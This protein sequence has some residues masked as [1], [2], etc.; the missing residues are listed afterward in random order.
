MN[1]FKHSHHQVLIMSYGLALTH[2]KTFLTVPCD[3]LICDEGHKLKNNNI[4]IFKVLNALKTKRKIVLSGTPLQNDLNEFYCIVDFLNPGLLGTEKSFKH[5][6]ADPINKS[7]EPSAKPA[8]K[9][10][11]LAR[12]QLLNQQIGQFVLRRTN[13]LLLEHLPPKGLFY[14]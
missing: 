14:F 4:K 11:G 5:V 9:S 8:E 13:K 12:S 3:L 7:R 6:F 1:T 2:A 10:V